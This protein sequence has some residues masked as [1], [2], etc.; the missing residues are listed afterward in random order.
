MPLLAAAHEMM[1]TAAILCDEA[2]EIEKFNDTVVRRPHHAKQHF[3]KKIGLYD[4]E[5]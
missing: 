1:R 4:K 3:L 5:Q 2:R